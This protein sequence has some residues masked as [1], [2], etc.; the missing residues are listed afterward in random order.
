MAKSETAENGIKKHMGFAISELAWGVGYAAFLQ[1]TRPGKWLANKQTWA[2]VVIG[3]GG[4]LAL[5]KQVTEW[6][7]LLMVSGAFVLSSLGIIAR[8]LTNDDKLDLALLG[9]GGGHAAQESTAMDTVV[10]GGWTRKL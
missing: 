1:F 10:W 5:A 7:P 8:S 9:E 6:R 2:S 3:V 4:T